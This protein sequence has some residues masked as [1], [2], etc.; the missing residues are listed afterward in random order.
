MILHLPFFFIAKANCFTLIFLNAT[1]DDLKLDLSTSSVR[2]GS[3]IN[4][5]KKNTLFVQQVKIK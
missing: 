2:K 1:N 3:E 4:Y 5:Y